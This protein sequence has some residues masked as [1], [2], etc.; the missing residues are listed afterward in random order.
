MF[1]RVIRF[2]GISEAEWKVGDGFFR[3]DFLPM[4]MST[5]GFDGAL[6]LVDRERGSVLS[7]TL[8]TSR[9]A[10]EATDGLARRFLGQYAAVSG[11]EPVVE[12]FEIAHAELP[13][14]PPR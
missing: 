8:W 6:L 12:T 7:L 10:L 3:E 11:S 9:E 5:T 2:D 4:A 13:G 1:A 14:R